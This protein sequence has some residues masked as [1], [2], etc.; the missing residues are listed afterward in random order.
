MF[1]HLL[2]YC[3]VILVSGLSH[4]LSDASTGNVVCYYMSSYGRSIAPPEKIDPNLC[5]HLNYAFVGLDEGGNLT[6]KNQFIDIGQEMYKRVVALKKINP[7]LKVLLS[8]GSTNASIFSKVAAH[9]N[10]RK[11][12]IE[13]TK[14][15]LETYSFDGV[16]VDWEL[17]LENDRVNFIELLR[18]LREVF[19]KHDWILSAAVHA[20]PSIGYNAPEMAKYLHMINLMCYV[21]Y[22]HWSRHTGQNSPLFAS[23]ADSSDEKRKR[24]IAASMKNWLDAGTPREKIN[25]GVAF[26][27]RVFTLA[28]PE[29]HGLHA[30]ITGIGTPHTPTYLQICLNCANWTTVWDDEQ[31]NHYKYHGNQWLGYDDEKSLREKARYI[32]SQEMAGVMIWQ[33]GQDDVFGDCGKKQ[34][35]LRAINDEL[36]KSLSAN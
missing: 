28:D 15:F 9:E 24:N 30:P 3:F 20:N 6:F 2:S 4:V 7:K 1:S 17:P 29:V 11:A 13:S 36:K 31:K 34:V 16:D 14:Y 21:Y 32:A 8:I 26:Y 19:D 18:E 22:G 33:I 12:L 23:S 35:L 5:T 10:S 27:G 25:V